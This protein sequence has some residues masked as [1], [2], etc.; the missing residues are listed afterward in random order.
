V[1][2]GIIDLEL[3]QE[4]IKSTQGRKLDNF[5]IRTDNIKL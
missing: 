1:G 2:F 3:E 5:D 4:K